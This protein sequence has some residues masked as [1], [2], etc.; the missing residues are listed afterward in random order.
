MGASHSDLHTAAMAA[1]E[2]EFRRYKRMAERAFEQLADQ[3]FFVRLNDRQNSI[4]VIIKHLAGN[5]RSRWTD[6]LT[7]DGEKPDRH[8]D[9]EFVEDIVPRAQVLKTWEGGWAYAFAALSQLKDGDL[10]RTVTI[11]GE[12]MTALS[13]IVRSIAHVANHVGHIILI[14]KHVKGPDWKWLTIPP[15]QSEQFT[16]QLRDK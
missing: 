4:W 7:T 16:R 10:V 8:R 9:G 14:A 3:D 5:M 15:G 1:F 2:A 6:F 12:P 11:R 13:A